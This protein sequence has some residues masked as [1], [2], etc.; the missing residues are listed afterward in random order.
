MVTHYRV[1]LATGS[2]RSSIRGHFKQSCSI[3]INLTSAIEAVVRGANTLKI[4]IFLLF[5]ARQWSL[6]VGFYGGINS[7]KR[8]D[9][10]NYFSKIFPKFFQTQVGQ[11][12]YTP[13][14]LINLVNMVGRDRFEL[15]TNGLKVRCSTS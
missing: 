13:K 12:L 7:R 10:G 11:F 3:I 14:L 8:D 4:E 9:F 15:S 2:Q 6:F 5:L 1:K